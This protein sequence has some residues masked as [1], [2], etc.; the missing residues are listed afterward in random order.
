MEAEVSGC[1]LGPFR[2]AQ[3]RP[4][5]P[6][7]GGHQKRAVA[8]AAGLAAGI[9]AVPAPP[10]GG[11]RCST[12]R[13]GDRT[14]SFRDGLGAVAAASGRLVAGSLG[15]GRAGRRGVRGRPLLAPA[16]PLLELRGGVGVPPGG[17]GGRVDF[18]ALG[19]E[20]ASFGFGD[21]CAVEVS[22]LVAL[23]V[24]PARGDARHQD[25]RDR[26]HRRDVVLALGDHEAVVAGGQGR[27]GLAARS[28]AR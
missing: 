4:L 10:R 18:V 6:R 13:A 12:R 26:V 11:H 1:H 28:A 9:A 8:A 2:S 16:R 15:A 3:W 14:P 19:A 20:G 5:N 25:G 17:A 24:A 22:E 27:V 7:G 21:G 23:P